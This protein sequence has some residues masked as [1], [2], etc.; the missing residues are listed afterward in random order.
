M[1][2]TIVTER[3]LVM[4]LDKL[5]RNVR[6]LLGRRKIVI[7][8]DHIDASNVL[9]ALSQSLVVH[10]IN[11]REINY[12]WRYYCGDQEI[13][14]RIKDVRPEICNKIVE[15][16]ANEIVSFWVGYLGGEPIQYVSRVGDEKI[17]EGINELNE[18]F[19]AEDKASSDEQ[20][21]EWDMICGTAYRIILPDEFYEKDS[22]EAP[23]EI[24]TLDPRY[25]FV[26]YSTGLGNKPLMGVVMKTVEGRSTYY[27]YTDQAMFTIYDGRITDER[28]HR[29]P[30][31]PMIEYPAN[32]ARLGAFEIVLPLLDAI[33][34]I[35]SNRMDGVEQEI[36]AFLKFINCDIDTEGLRKLSEWGA[37][38]VKS[39]PGMTADVDVVKTNLDQNQSQAFK[40]DLYAAVLSICGIPNRNGGNSTSDT[41]AAVV[42]RDGWSAAEARA[43]DYEHMFKI[44]EKHMLK[45][46]LA[47]C[48]DIA[49]LDIS[50]KDI[51]QK[52]TRRNYENIQSKAQ[53]LCE[54]LQQA[55]IHPKLAF[56]HSGLFSDPESAY[57]MSEEFYKQQMEEWKLQEVDSNE[58][59][60]AGTGKE[61]GTGKASVQETGQVSGTDRKE[62]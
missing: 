55:R 14:Y 44:A 43:K 45:V 9:D 56:M 2:D 53:V 34:N 59:K 12:L 58:S 32:H 46:A 28:P 24:Y 49:D 41:G 31:L 7:D 62:D 4:S 61:S 47:I 38:K 42:L 8:Y 36:Q 10:E 6:P 13:L 17:T 11:A 25:A 52:F 20:L 39:V 27:V 5:D 18:F 48:K 57:A 1:A 50:L 35:A 30:A 26:S 15:N 3:D 23:F 37:I 54:M 60:G 40:E 19:F 21:I 22:D 16:R 51:D 29:L 33:N